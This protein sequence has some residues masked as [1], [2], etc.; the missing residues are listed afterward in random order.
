MK[1]EEEL[2]QLF[3]DLA[4]IESGKE[5][6]DYLR[7]NNSFLYKDQIKELQQ[8]FYTKEDI[9]K[10]F[11]K[12]EIKF[13]IVSFFELNK[14]LC[15]LMGNINHNPGR[16]IAIIVKDNYTKKILG[17]IRLSSPPLNMKPRTEILGKISYEYLNKYFYTGTVI[18]SV[19]DFGYYAL[20]GK[21]LTLICISDEIRTI[22]NEKYGTNLLWFETTALYGS[23]KNI[24][25]YDGLGS[26]L[27][28]GI[29]TESNLYMFLSKKYNDIYYSFLKKYP[30]L[31]ISRTKSSARM[32]EYPKVIKFLIEKGYLP[33]EI[34]KKL[35]VKTKKR[36]YYCPIT[37]KT[38]EFLSGDTDDWGEIRK[39]FS[40]N[41][42]IN[43]WKIKAAKRL[44]KKGL[45]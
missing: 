15:F 4:E 35:K 24:S 30:Y 22:W 36:Y 37:T 38:K 11:D 42:L 44:I 25:Q 28:R 8:E 20:G 7:E 5:Y 33:K 40:L 27:Y 1:I 23:E 19:P 2:A 14:Y 43:Y 13:E 39:D 17:F 16:K 34:K 41:T 21:L 32:S 26:Y 10:N 31:K 29:L 12:I 3:L 6:M 9:I 18:V 45:L